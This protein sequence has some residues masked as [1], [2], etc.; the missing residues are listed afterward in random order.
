[1]PWDRPIGA[2]IADSVTDLAERGSITLRL[3]FKVSNLELDSLVEGASLAVEDP[4]H[5]RLVYDL[6]L[7]RSEVGWPA[8]RL[9]PVA[10]SLAIHEVLYPLVRLN[11]DQAPANGTY[12]VASGAPLLES[13]SRGGPD[14]E[15]FT[16][17]G[18]LSDFG[19]MVKEEYFRP[20]SLLANWV[21][22]L[23]FVSRTRQ[24]EHSV[25]LTED[26]LLRSDGG[27]LARHFQEL[28]NNH[29]Q[30]WEE[31]KD[32]LRQLVPWLRDVYT[33]IE[34]TATSAKVAVREQQDAAEAFA[35][36]NMGSG[37]VHIMTIT[38]MVWST[39]DGGLCLIEEPEAGLH[40]T[41]K[42]DLLLWL[43]WHARERDKQLIMATHSTLFSRP[44]DD[45]SVY[46]ATYDPE[47]GT[48]FHRIGLEDT[49]D[50][51]RELGVRLAD[52]YSYDCVL[53]AEGDS[54]M[55]ALPKILEA[56]DVDLDALGV[57]L[58]PLKGGTTARLRRLREYL[59]YLRRSQVLPFIMLDENRGVRSAVQDLISSRLI[60]EKNV[61]LWKRGEQSAGE[62]EDNFTDDQ[63]LRAVNQLAASEG[64]DHPPLDNPDLEALRAKK[65]KTM[66]S[67]L[68]AELYYGRHQ[69]GLPKPRLAVILGDLAAK[70][71]RHGKRD[72]QFVAAIER[73]REA[74][75][76]RS[77]LVLG[78]ST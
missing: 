26:H 21:E 11:A 60:D 41:A 71:I 67:K 29:P 55:H 12:Q 54:E 39:P 24:G 61:W 19:D 37:T 2:V 20:Y 10:A 6:A 28:H 62:F 9:V 74:V 78:T 48:E 56:L 40:D 25:T 44:G 76:T 15:V 58:L 7:K 3:E 18:G 16:N 69:Y 57:H 14:D 63:L 33:P 46:L 77:K 8:D 1:M 50:V 34:E 59:T 72:Y 42:R 49:P 13:I 68:L 27:N 38:A 5:I 23:R 35:L 53:F 31:L 17:Y 4:E 65:P 70:D 66:T 22:R 64:S 73:L 75:G 52:L 30:R 32:I 51:I 43:G 45:V 36:A 47:L